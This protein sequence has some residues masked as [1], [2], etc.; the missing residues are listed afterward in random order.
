MK[1]YLRHSIENVIDIKELLALEYLD[2]NGK[3]KDYCEAHEFWEFCY[4]EE[5]ELLHLT[6]PA[7]I[8]LSR[9]QAILLPPSREHSYRQIQECRAFVICFGSPSQALHPLAADKFSLS[10]AQTSAMKIILQEA[11]S[12]FRM[13]DD[14]QLVVLDTP[15]FG[16]QQ[17]I[18]AQ[19]E[20]LLI[21]AARRFSSEEDASIVFLNGKDFYADLVAILL[22]YFRQNVRNQLNLDT[23]C[24]KMN[25][26]R[27][28][29]CRT[30]KQQTGETLMACF[31]RLKIEEAQR[32]LQDTNLSPTRI[33][34]ELSF[35]DVKYFNSLFKKQTGYS[36]VAYRKK[37][38]ERKEDSKHDETH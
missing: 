35:S 8:S 1:T 25:Y 3:Y 38:H 18:I 7:E 11:H 31:N 17:V 15:L 22:R 29:L 37:Y 24:R 23:I 30:F 13:N 9:G 28:F 10:E 19:L 5:G 2:F 21:C 26:S 12:T 14:D 4:V 20:Y 34:E 6:G 33:A 32:M 16:G 27:S 36:P